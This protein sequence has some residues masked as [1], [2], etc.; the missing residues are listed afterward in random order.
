MMHIASNR[1]GLASRLKCLISVM[2]LNKV[3]RLYWEYNNRLQCKW[4]LLFEN[5]VLAKES[6]TENI[7]LRKKTNAP[8]T[9]AHYSWR[10]DSTKQ[11]RELYK[12][13]DFDWMYDKTPKSIRDGIIAQINKLKPIK[14]CRDEIN[15]FRANFD[16]N[17]VSVCVRTWKDVRGTN[18]ERPFKYAWVFEHTDKLPEDAKIFLTSDSRKTLKE[19][20][21][22]YGTNRIL[23]YPKRTYWGDWLSV[24]GV[25]DTL[26]ELY[27]GGSNTK[28]YLSWHSAFTEAQWWFGGAKAEVIEV[29]PYK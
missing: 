10:F 8:K 13:T 24:E 3:Y 26:I 5:N 22:R 7:R 9:I 23:Y 15:K 12:K 18:L 28:M 16:K 20:Q 4:P 1:E 19:F 25:Q 2:R 11:E 17:T 27:L 6:L 21:N 14:Y 29:A